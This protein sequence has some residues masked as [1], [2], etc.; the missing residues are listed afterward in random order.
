M[1]AISFL[2]AMVRPK[3]RS[4]SLVLVGSNW[5][6]DVD[7]EVSLVR[8]LP[9]LVIRSTLG[10]IFD[11]TAESVALDAPVSLLSSDITRLNTD[12]DFKLWTVY[13]LLV[14]STCA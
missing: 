12:D 3:S 11:L 9:D 13:D 5:L 4:D 6:M 14:L 2:S 10:Y 7:W 8:C 1:S